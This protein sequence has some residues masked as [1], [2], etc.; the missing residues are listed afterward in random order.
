MGTLDPTDSEGSSR[1]RAK[2]ASQRP[3]SGSKPSQ[4]ALVA[5]SYPNLSPMI[6]MNNVVL[7]QVDQITHKKS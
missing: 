7:K 4:P 6:I 5:G 1:W 3:G 2:R